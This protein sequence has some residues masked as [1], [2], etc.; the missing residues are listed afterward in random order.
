MD[1]ET[2]KDIESIADKLTDMILFKK[3]SEDD[4]R[5]MLVIIDKLAEISVNN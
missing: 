5:S 2:I 1:N 4:C 3:L